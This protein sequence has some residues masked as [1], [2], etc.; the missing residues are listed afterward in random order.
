M[1]NWS[2]VKIGD[3]FQ[4]PKN[5]VQDDE[6]SLTEDTLKYRGIRLIRVPNIEAPPSVSDNTVILEGENR[7]CFIRIGSKYTNGGRYPEVEIL[8]DKENFYND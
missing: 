7:G 2:A 4:I 5:Y 8:N 6:W 1:K 3:V